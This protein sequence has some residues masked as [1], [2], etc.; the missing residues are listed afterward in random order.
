MFN[1]SQSRYDLQPPKVH[2]SL[3]F[4]SEK[5]PITLTMSKALH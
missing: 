5:Q 3:Y 4:P 1:Q 2:F